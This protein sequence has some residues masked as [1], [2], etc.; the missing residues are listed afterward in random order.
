MGCALGALLG[1]GCQVPFSGAGDWMP[2]LGSTGANI[3]P[4]ACRSA[5][6]CRAS[7]LPAGIGGTI[8]RCNSARCLLL[9]G[10]QR[11]FASIRQV[12]YNA[13]QCCMPACPLVA[14]T[15]LSAAACTLEVSTRTTTC[16]VPRMQ[17]DSDKAV[18]VAG[19]VDAFNQ[20]LLA[21]QIEW[22]KWDQAQQ[23]KA[24]GAEGAR[25]LENVASGSTA[26]AAPA[27]AAAAAAAAAA[28][29][30]AGMTGGRAAL[31]TAAPEAGT[32]AAAAAAAAAGCEQQQPLDEVNDVICDR[33]MRGLGAASLANCGGVP[34]QVA[35]AAAEGGSKAEA[36]SAWLLQVSRHHPSTPACL[37]LP[38]DVTCTAS[39]A[40]RS[41]CVPT[42]AASMQHKADISRR[43]L[44]ALEHLARS[45]MLLVPFMNVVNA[46]VEQELDAAGVDA[47]SSPGA[48]AAG[49]VQVQDAGGAAEG[50]EVV[51]GTPRQG[52][53][54]QQQQGEGAALTTTAEMLSWLP[55]L[56]LAS[57]HQ[58]LAFIC[59]QLASGLQGQQSVQDAL[60]VCAC[61]PA[62]APARRQPAHAVKVAVWTR[63][64]C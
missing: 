29:D 60:Q 62:C 48:A 17:P 63:H 41:E 18:A 8:A 42:C 2:G 16:S 46:F 53:P 50:P 40:A 13:L 20:W 32:T 28:N 27:D 35:A 64:Y 24:R 10:W 39:T 44:F 12:P 56:P 57:L 54:Q 14:C 6:G 5:C 11:S 30:L 43:I 19:A 22:A 34:P 47:N 26:E 9:W 7:A 61:L 55:H 3:Q 51:D 59:L 4:P 45:G 52:G 1:A 36:A 23:E 37:L 21:H 58:L 31:E 38:A 49:A 33:L 25:S 15:V